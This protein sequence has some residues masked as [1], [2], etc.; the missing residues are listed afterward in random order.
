M[1]PKTRTDDR[2]ARQKVLPEIGARGQERLLA[3]T[4][5]VI[6]CGALGSTQAELLVRAGVGRVRIADR[7]LVELNNLQRQL[8]F[9]ESDVAER[10][11]KAEAAARKLRRI[12]SSVV[13]EP[14]VLDVTPGNL[15]SLLEGV[16]VVIDATDN[17]E[18][19]YLIN[20]ACVERGIP[21]VY[22]GAVGTSG[23]VMPIRPGQG[24]CLRCLFA[25]P[26]PPG[27]L[28]TCEIA[29]VLNTAPAVIAALQVTEAL[30][31]LTGNGQPAGGIL[32]VDVWSGSFRSVGV[33]RDP[34]CTC[35]GQRKFE[36]LEAKQTSMATSLC[37]RNAIQISPAQPQEIA[38]DS[39]AG[40]L[41]GQGEVSSNGLLLRFAV[42]ELELMVFPDGRAIVKGTDDPAV[43][44]SFYAKWV[45]A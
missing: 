37:G 7:D 22:G 33:K 26:P 32:T 3:S 39:L 6:G 15:P 5:L 11:P 10:L 30:K 28:P 41:A 40:R 44:R 27:S 19:R 35:C 12:N 36:F 34:S 8:L 20:D 31:L 23:M 2:Y 1:V 45:G 21:W 43:A 18:T 14:R 4:A 9:E 29:G 13:V 38:L 17:I 25:E 16:T 42:D 24:P